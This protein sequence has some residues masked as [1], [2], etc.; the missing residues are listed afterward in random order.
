MPPAGDWPQWRG[1]HANGVSEET[2][3]AVEWSSSHNI[4]WR[5]PLPGLGTSTPIVWEGRVFVTS[6]VGDGPFEQRG[7]DFESAVDARSGRLR[8]S[9]SSI[10]N[11]SMPISHS[12]PFI[13]GLCLSS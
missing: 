9:G 3:L 4:A 13:E 11:R 10:L 1:P 5:T 8:S 6:Q 2:G 12:F 7:R